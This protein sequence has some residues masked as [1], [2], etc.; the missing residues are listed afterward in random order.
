MQCWSA[1]HVP[2]LITRTALASHAARSSSRRRLVTRSTCAPTLAPILACSS[3]PKRRVKPSLTRVLGY[4][5][6]IPGRRAPT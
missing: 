3:Q 1:F 6:I 2:A 5:L 4:I